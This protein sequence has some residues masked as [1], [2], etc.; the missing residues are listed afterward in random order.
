[1]VF[2][3]GTAGQEHMRLPNSQLAD[4]LTCEFRDLPTFT[5]EFSARGQVLHLRKRSLLL[6]NDLQ[7]LTSS[8]STVLDHKYVLTY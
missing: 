4:S 6:G 8:Y 7:N 1:M 3:V 5:V 2:R